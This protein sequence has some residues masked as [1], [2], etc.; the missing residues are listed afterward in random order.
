[1]A[2]LAR[3]FN[4]LHPPPPGAA[5]LHLL[6]DMFAYLYFRIWSGAASMAASCRQQSFQIK[7]TIFEPEFTSLVIGEPQALASL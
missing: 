5:P 1:M 4:A 2:T 7:N 3:P 6:N